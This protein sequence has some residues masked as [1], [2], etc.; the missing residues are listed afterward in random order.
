MKRRIQNW[1]E[2]TDITASP[3]LYLDEYDGE[4]SLHTPPP[5]LEDDALWAELLAAQKH[6]R[7]VEARVLAAA[8]EVPLDEFEVE[9]GRKLWRMTGGSLADYDTDEFDRI[10]AALRKHAGEEP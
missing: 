3:H 7:E 4:L 5:L 10:Q 8:K 6:L 2:M 9:M 1:D